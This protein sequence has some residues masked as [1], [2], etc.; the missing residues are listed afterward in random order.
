MDFND[1]KG[2]FAEV[3]ARMSKVA[4]GRMEAVAAAAGRMAA[5]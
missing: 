3:K 4:G 5:A 2:M 1:L